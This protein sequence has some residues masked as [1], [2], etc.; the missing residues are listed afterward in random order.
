MRCA[1]PL[2]FWAFSDASGTSSVQVGGLSVGAEV[3]NCAPGELVVVSQLELDQY[4]AS[5]FRLTLAEGG[6]LATAIVL[7]WA[8]GFGVRM[9][10]RAINTADPAPPSE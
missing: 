4:T 10:A 8:V 6:A 9:A 3:A 2:T 1:T 5:P 7:V